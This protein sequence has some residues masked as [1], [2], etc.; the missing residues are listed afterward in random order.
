MILQQGQKFWVDNR[1]AKK[2]QFWQS[3]GQSNLERPT[4]KANQRFQTPSRVIDFNDAAPQAM[5]NFLQNG[6]SGSCFRRQKV[7]NRLSISKLSKLILFKTKILKSRILF[8]GELVFHSA[9]I[10]QRWFF[11]ELI[12]LNE[13]FILP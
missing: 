2:F 9:A 6:Y 12:D 13:G 3:K 4:P 5:T 10:P 7:D 8:R 11:P 1:S